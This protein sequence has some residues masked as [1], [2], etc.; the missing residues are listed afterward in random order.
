MTKQIQK[1]MTDFEEALCLRLGYL[2][3]HFEHCEDYFRKLWIARGIV[4]C[5]TLLGVDKQVVNDRYFGVSI[6]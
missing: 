2:L 6:N 4:S 5:Y 1:N 3:Y